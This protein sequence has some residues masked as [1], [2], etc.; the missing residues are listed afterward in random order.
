MGARRR[1]GLRSEMVTWFR[2]LTCICVSG[3]RPRPR[4]PVRGGELRPGK[5]GPGLRNVQLA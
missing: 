5:D 2:A 1:P 3:W 4:P